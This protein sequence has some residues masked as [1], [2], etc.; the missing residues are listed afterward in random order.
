M[1]L[2]VLLIFVI[3]FCF[4]QTGYVANKGESSFGIWLE[5]Y[6]PIE[7]DDCNPVNSLYFDYIT[8]F[9]LE[10]GLGIGQSTME[11][12]GLEADLDVNN[13]H[14]TYHFNAPNGGNY[15]FGYRNEKVTAD[16]G[17]ME[18]SLSTDYYD[19]SL[20]SNNGFVFSILHYNMK[21]EI[22]TGEILSWEKFFS[23]GN[24]TKIGMSYK[25]HTDTIK[26]ALEDEELDYLKEGRITLTV[27]TVF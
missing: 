18:Y 1:R 6:R 16:L 27:G 15:S 13:A 11:E 24:I 7:C 21:D 9:G 26:D 17:F 14:L 3:T 19:L 2:F 10:V 5:S 25:I 8:P 23:I 20:Y 4:T 12:Y 22:G